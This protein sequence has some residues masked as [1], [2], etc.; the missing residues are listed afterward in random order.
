[1]KIVLFSAVLLCV[2][3]I[4]DTAHARRVNPVKGAHGFK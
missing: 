4:T 1:M 3:M 2:L